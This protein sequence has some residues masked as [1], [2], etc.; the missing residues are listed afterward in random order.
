MR[1]LPFIGILTALA[2]FITAG[3]AQYKPVGNAEVTLVALAPIINEADVPQI[4]APL[5]RNLRERLNHSPNWRLVDE[6]DAEV[7]LRVT[8]TGR[9]RDAVARD[10]VD[11][12]R[13]LSYYETLFLNLEWESDLPAPWGPRPVT[14]IEADSL[15]YAQPSLVTAETAAVNE[16]A[17]EL[18][19]KIVARMGWPR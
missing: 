5:A 1:P 13:P 15:L 16:L 17:D 14:R 19:R 2:A 9:E 18:A 4:I 7:L 8:L 3:C 6:A 10:P 12:G 11:T